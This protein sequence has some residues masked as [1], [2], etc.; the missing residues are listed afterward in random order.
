MVSLIC[1]VAG[2]RRVGK[3]HEWL[4]APCYRIGDRDLSGE[5]VRPYRTA[6]SLQVTLTPLLGEVK[7]R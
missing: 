7:V 5:H 1:K 6:A 4:R 3:L 2:R